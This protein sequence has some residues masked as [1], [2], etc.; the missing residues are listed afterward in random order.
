MGSQQTSPPPTSPSSTPLSPEKL[1][2]DASKD[3]NTCLKHAQCMWCTD[4]TKEKGCVPYPVGSVFPI[5][6]CAGG[7]DAA[8]WGVCWVNFKILLIVMG[9]LAGVILISCSCCIYCCCCRRKQNKKKYEQEEATYER[10]KEERRIK[11]EE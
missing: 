11:S 6:K 7:M 5:H 1:C 8:R 10:Q 9:C 3:C 2:K 4:T